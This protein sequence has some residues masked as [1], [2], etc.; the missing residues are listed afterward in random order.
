MC[1]REREK[2]RER[3]REGGRKRE[4]EEKTRIVGGQ[5]TNLCE[6]VLE[7][8]YKQTFL[9]TRVLTRRR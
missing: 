5:L 4:R 7:L 9:L 3:E 6:V 8:T 1:E 2:E